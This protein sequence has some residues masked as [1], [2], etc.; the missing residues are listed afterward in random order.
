MSTTELRAAQQ[1]GS[2]L[3]DLATSKGV[4]RDDLLKSIAAD[5]KAGRPQGASPLSD[6]QLTKIAGA[7]ADG[8]R[9]SGVGGAHAHHHHQGGGTK[10]VASDPDGDGDVD[11][12]GATTDTDTQTSGLN[13]LASALG[14]DPAKL[15]ARIQST[16]GL[17]SLL[18]LDAKPGYSSSGS[19][20]SPSATAVGTSGLVVDALA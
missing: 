7:I 17:S 20:T 16:S 19:A 2:T 14:I 11:G 8:K 13:E 1:S 10:S 9:P 15:L 4:S 18:S 12:A 6:D 3:A 5:V